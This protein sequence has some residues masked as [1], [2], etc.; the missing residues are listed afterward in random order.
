M[1]LGKFEQAIPY[2]QQ[3]LAHAD[4]GWSDERMQVQHKFAICLQMMGE[5]L[6]AYEVEHQ[7]TKERYNWAENYI[8][9][10]EVCAALDRWDEVE[11]WANL[12]LRYGMP[13]SMLILNPLEFK[14]IPYA[15]LAEAAARQGRYDE[16]DGFAAQALEAAQIGR[17]HV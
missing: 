12:A 6:A 3:Y 14:L 11:H 5:H 4:A 10:T 16:A 17:A 7:A 2:L 13:Q 9:L 15:R 8:G 1:A